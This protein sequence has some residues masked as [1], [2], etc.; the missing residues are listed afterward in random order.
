MTQQGSPDEAARRK[1][2][3]RLAILAAV[4]ALASVIGGFSGAYWTTGQQG[5]QQRAQDQRQASAALNQAHTQF[6]IEQQQAAYQRVFQ[7]YTVLGKEYARLFFEME[8]QHS[9]GAALPGELA[10]L[11]KLSSA[12]LYAGWQRILIDDGSLQTAVDGADVVASP[13]TQKLADRLVDE[14]D[15]YESDIGD[16]AY[17]ADTDSV[18]EYVQTLRTDFSIDKGSNPEEEAFA[19]FKDAARDDLTKPTTPP[20]K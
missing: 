16:L 11:H 5:S 15:N 12:Q 6:I 19:A 7:A 2:D 18:H 17:E 8:D 3:A 1:L 14:A 10:S 20:P 9:A 13:T 4:C